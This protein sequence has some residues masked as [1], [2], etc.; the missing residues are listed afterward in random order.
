LP[1][2]PP[3]ALAGGTQFDNAATAIA[4]VEDIA[5]PLAVS[6]ADVAQGLTSVR[7][8]GR[9]QVV[10]PA[11]TGRPTWILDV[12]HNPDAAA[13]LARNLRDLPAAG[14]TLG[15]CGVLADKDAAG[16]AARLRNSIDAWWLASTDGARGTSSEELAARIEAQIAAPLKLAGNIAAACAAALAAAGPLDRIVVFGSFHTVGPAMDWLEARGMLPPDA[17]HEYTGPPRGF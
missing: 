11:R 9:F 16:V 12:A 1:D 10:A 6:A 15:V 2:L 5:P 14:R 3:P 13:V 8:S 4:A 17:L 7:L